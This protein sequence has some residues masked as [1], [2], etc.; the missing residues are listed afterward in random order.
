MGDFGI[1]QDTCG[2]PTRAPCVHGANTNVNCR[3]FFRVTMS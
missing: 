3:K 1:E 2:L